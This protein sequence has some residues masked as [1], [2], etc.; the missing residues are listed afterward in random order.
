MM[1]IFQQVKTIEIHLIMNA[2]HVAE[3]MRL[4]INEQLTKLEEDPYMTYHLINHIGD[5]EAR[6]IL[7]FKLS[8]ILLQIHKMGKF[9]KGMRMT[10]ICED[11]IKT[12]KYKALSNHIYQVVFLTV[13]VFEVGLKEVLFSRYIYNGSSRSWK[14]MWSLW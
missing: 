3:E 10:S 7:W 8:I 14:Y 2:R 4:L 12:G 5:D 11:V 9:G 13:L 6:E 1:S